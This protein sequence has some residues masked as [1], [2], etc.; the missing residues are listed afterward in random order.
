[1]LTWHDGRFWH[2]GKEFEI[3]SGAIHYFRSLPDRWREL[4]L[5]LKYCGMNAVETY[6][7]WNL[8]EPREGDFDFSG[9]LDVVRFIRT[10]QE[11]GLYVILRPGPFICAEWEFGGFPAWMLTRVEHFRTREGEYLTYVRKYMEQLFARLRPLLET[12]GGP[13][14]MVAAENEY[15]SFGNDTQ[16]MNA[17]AQLLRDVGVDVPIF[18]A[19]GRRT[20]F[21]QGGHADGCL[22]A[23]DY[24]YMQGHLRADQHDAFHRFQPDAPVFNVEHWDGF[25]SHWGK[26]LRTYDG[27]LLAG[28]V[29]DHLDQHDSFNLYMFHGGTNFGFLNGANAFFEDPENRAKPTYWAD[30]TSYDY[31]APLTEWGEITPKYL[32]VK[33]VMEKHLG[34]TFPVPEPVPLMSLG[35]I[36]L[37]HSAELFGQ[38]GRI[39]GVHHSVI[40]HT[41]EYYGQDYGYILYR[42]KVSAGNH[43][44]LLTFLGVGDRVNVFFNGVWRGVVHRND[45]EK[46]VDVDGWMEEGGTLDL[47]VENLGRVNFSVEMDRGDPKGLTAGVCLKGDARQMLTDFDVYTLPMDDLQNISWSPVET[48]AVECPMFYRGQFRAEKKQ[49]CFVHPDGFGK[50]FVVVNGFNLGRYWEIGPQRSLFLPREILRDENEI[51]VFAEKPVRDPKVSILDRHILDSMITEEQPYTIV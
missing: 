30:V 8:H 24:G 45:D 32:A 15:G 26:P 40:P 12:N 22:C 33:A 9:R 47:L 11:L 35:E 39:G 13:I 18:T 23:L 14:L 25:L 10:A 5:K 3:H 41:M 17:C 16:Y 44:T 2:D 28:E 20:M 36:P 6:C 19:D 7:A 4:L 29:Q 37:T 38:L 46:C 48:P 31:G 49:D 51:I 1:M 43:I 50:G 21:L 27:E 42:T 34:V